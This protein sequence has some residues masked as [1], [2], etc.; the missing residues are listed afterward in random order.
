MSKFSVG[1]DIG[2]Y[3]IKVVVAE[4]SNE[5]NTLPK[6]IGAGFAESKGLRHGYI[7]NQ[8]DAIKS[9]R[10]AVR[11]AEK[12]SKRKIE[13]A[14]I[15]IGGIGL[16]SQI[17]N[18]SIMI[19]RADSE[20]TELD[21]EKV[22]KDSNDNV[23]KTFIQNRQIIHSIPIEYKVDGKPV[24]GLN[25][26]GMKGVKL[27]V[28]TLFIASLTH[29]LQEL[30]QVI[31]ASGIEIADVMAAPLAA[32]LVT[33]SKT[34][35]IAGS[36][37]ANIGSDTVTIVVYE[38]DIPI[39]LEVFPIGSNDITN[40]IALGLKVSLEEAE[41]IKRK[42]D[43]GV[44]EFEFPKKKLDE[45]VTARMS[46]IFELIDAH[47]KKIG[48]SGLLPAGIIITGGGAGII[49][50]EDMAKASLKLPSKMAN[51]TTHTEFFNNATSGAG[52][53]VK[54]ATWAIS[55]GLCVFGLH[56]DDDGSISFNIGKT[57]FKKT[58]RKIVTWFKKFLP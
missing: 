20:I 48:K 1:I 36:V 15:S 4:M 40:D 27:E 45:I 33:L 16:S 23:P 49:N 39:S 17:S 19:S 52:V 7:I 29:H 9:I 35:K 37:L 50:I 30:I 6:I 26:V 47:L 12:S 54:D 18:G 32:G 13:R 51:I 57:L 56:A 46:D 11:Q 58:T 38:D 53:K 5:S 22:G 43:E 55:Y 8:T 28:K 2:T 31:E 21:I 34:E 10:R 3:Q 41:K 25:P 42:R 44:Q 14:Y 24:L